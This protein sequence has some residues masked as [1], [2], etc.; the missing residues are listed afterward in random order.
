MHSPT[1][2]Y[3]PLTATF[4]LYANRLAWGSDGD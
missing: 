3:G 2:H 1:R 4:D